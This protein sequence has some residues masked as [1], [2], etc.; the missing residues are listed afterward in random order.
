MNLTLKNLNLKPFYATEFSAGIDIYTDL[1]DIPSL[2]I[3]ANGWKAISTGL[4][5]EIDPGKVGLVFIRSGL[6]FKHE[7]GLVN[8]VGV[9]DADFRGEIKVGIRNFGVNP[10]HLKTYTRIAQMVIIN[11][12][13]EALNLV[14]ALSSTVRGEGGYGSTGIE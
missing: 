9:I 5:V 6:A 7:L 4:C 1:G 2:T 13:K 12:E 3:P 11:Y 14:H 8:G 10:Y